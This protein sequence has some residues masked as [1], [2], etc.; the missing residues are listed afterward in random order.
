MK[1]SFIFKC[2]FILLLGSIFFNIN[3]HTVFAQEIFHE[4]S[5][6]GMKIALPDTMQVITVE[7]DKDDLAFSSLGLDYNET[8]ENFASNNI[9]LQGVDVKKLVSLTVTMN[10]TDESTAVGNYNNLTAD[11]LN[12]VKATFENNP[13]YKS[14]EI[15]EYNGEKYLFVLMD[16]DSN[17]EVV[18]SYQCITVVNGENCVISLQCTN[19]RKAVHK[20]TFETIMNSV[21][22]TQ[23]N[24][25]T[26]NA[27]VILWVSVSVLS[28]GV[29]IV[30][31]VLLYR[32][33][34]SPKRRHKN[35][36]HELA[37]EHRISETTQIARKKLYR[38][39]LKT[40]PPERDFMEEYSPFDDVTD[41]K[42]SA[43]VLSETKEFKGGTEYFT[44]L[45]QDNEMYVYSDVEKAVDDYETAKSKE[46]QRSRREKREEK[47]YKNTF[48]KV[49]SII[50][51]GV[52]SFFETVFVVI[53]YLV[54]HIKYFS[55][56]V[57]RLI[58]RKR[59]QKKHEKIMAEKRERAEQRKKMQREAELR[60]QRENEN[61]GENDLIKVRSRSEGRTYPRSGSY[62]RSR[63]RR[64]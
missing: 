3:I 16:M 11:E 24:F 19:G 53:C 50:G 17:G 21:E 46:K 26:Q 63:N 41:N 4:V 36:V 43:E 42:K 56:N 2:L 40:A 58:K 51:K 38:Y 18:E 52:L 34:K 15:K 23:Q 39:M 13:T 5:Q 25:F 60:R 57:Y 10:V 64:R 47:E 59:A 33:F 45:P 32:Y 55:I 6:I 12:Q 22:F 31:F 62:N 44:D 49:V 9:Y 14:C 20:K 7:S 54:V 28:I 61:R 29:V 48:V 1:K 8:M 35:L 30:A 27:T 37:H